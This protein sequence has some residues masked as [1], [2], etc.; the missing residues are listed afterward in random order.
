MW[1]KVFVDQEAKKTQVSDFLGL[2]RFFEC[3]A[4][5]RL[6]MIVKKSVRRP[7]GEKITSVRFSGT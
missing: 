3:G 7:G 2:S 6:S 5:K 1:K 4:K